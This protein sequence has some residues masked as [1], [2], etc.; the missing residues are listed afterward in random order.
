MPPIERKETIRSLALAGTRLDTALTAWNHDLNRTKEQHRYDP[1]TPQIT[2]SKSVPDAL[3]ILASSLAYHNSRAQLL[4]RPTPGL[5]NL[6]LAHI[7]PLPSTVTQD[8]HVKRCLAEIEQD[9]LARHDEL[10]L[11]EQRHIHGLESLRDLHR[12][13]LEQEK[14]GKMAVI[15]Q[16]LHLADGARRLLDENK[17]VQKDTNRAEY[18]QL[19]WQVEQAIDLTYKC[20]AALGAHDRSI[21]PLLQMMSLIT[22]KIPRQMMITEFFKARH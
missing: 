1:S 6:L 15:F 13:L 10:G 20:R 3:M 18:E 7:K 4:D 5:I 19:R 2:P 17:R 16:A 9:L 11:A 21:N 14:S 8:W 22:G 12:E